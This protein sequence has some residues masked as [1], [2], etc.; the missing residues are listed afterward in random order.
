M[1]NDIKV[2][3]VEGL[4]SGNYKQGPSYLKRGDQFCCLGVLC[5]LHSK[6]TDT[7][8]VKSYENDQGPRYL[9]AYDV[10]PQKV[11]DWAGLTESNPKIID[12]GLSLAELNDLGKTF[13]EIAN[14]ID[15]AL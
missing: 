3:W 15:H 12:L 5:D 1:N 14:I 2:K 9:G 7:S 13:E 6:E 10:L 4:Q 8:W 11:M